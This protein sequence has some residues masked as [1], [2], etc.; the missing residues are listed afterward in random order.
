MK[1]GMLGLSYSETQT[2]FGKKNYENTCD[3]FVT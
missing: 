1:F 2:I 3:E